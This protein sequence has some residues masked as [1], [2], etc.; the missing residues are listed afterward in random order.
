MT[1]QCA[2][3]TLALQFRGYVLKGTSEGYPNWAM[4]VVLLPR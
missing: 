3:R 2:I 1:A 4:W